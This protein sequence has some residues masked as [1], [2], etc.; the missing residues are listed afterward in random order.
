MFISISCVGETGASCYR[1]VLCKTIILVAKSSTAVL[2]ES[3]KGTTDERKPSM[4][5]NYS[6]YG[7][8]SLF[9]PLKLFYA[10]SQFFF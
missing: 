9:I 4:H 1:G 2:S 3:T 8:K 7:Q 5:A 6:R 10:S